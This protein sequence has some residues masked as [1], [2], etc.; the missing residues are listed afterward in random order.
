MS[1]E[2]QI[3]TLNTNIVA[4]IGALQAGGVPPAAAKAET[5]KTDK[6]AATKPAAKTETP[7]PVEALDY[8]K[9]V[10]PA[11]LA[12]AAKKGRDALMKV[13]GEFGAASA[14]D[15]KPESFASLI[16]KLNAAAAA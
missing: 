10:K 7:A 11:A 6:P 9:H 14:K 13:L 16:E 12:L 2:V 3:E 4:L 1:L 5:P 15:V 8:E